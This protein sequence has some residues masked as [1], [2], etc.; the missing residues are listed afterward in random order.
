MGE[1]EWPVS[2]D[3]KERSKQIHLRAGQILQRRSAKLGV[4]N[5]LHQSPRMFK[6]I[7]RKIEPVGLKIDFRH[8][9]NILDYR[10][11]SEKIK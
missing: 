4:R 6:E 1:L 3:N 11:I 5:W 2:G 8:L 7:P 9:V 10:R